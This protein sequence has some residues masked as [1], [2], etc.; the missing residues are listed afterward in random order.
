MED[1]FIV[2][3]ARDAVN[4]VPSAKVSGTPMLEARPAG[5]MTAQAIAALAE[6]AAPA[7][8]A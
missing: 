5:A 4:R 8:T 7:Q 6:P 3:L 2:C 1:L